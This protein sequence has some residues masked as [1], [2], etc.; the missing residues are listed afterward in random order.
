TMEWA[1][2][3]IDDVMGWA[4]RNQTE[5]YEAAK[6]HQAEAFEIGRRA[7]VERDAEISRLQEALRAAE[8]DANAQERKSAKIPSQDPGSRE[9]ESMIKL[10][11]GMAVRRYKYN[12]AL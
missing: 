5:A 11:I 9:R 7:L 8:A 10:I 2:T 4:K 1:K 3:Q 12:P 6:K